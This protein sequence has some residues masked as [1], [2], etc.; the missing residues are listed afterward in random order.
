MKTAIATG[1]EPR[2][3]NVRAVVGFM[4]ILAVVIAVLIPIIWYM[5]RGLDNFFAGQDP[6][7]SPVTMERPVPLAP[8]QRSPGHD[9]LDWQDMQTMRT[10]QEAALSSTTYDPATG[11]GHISI[12]QAMDL[13]LSHNMLKTASPAAAPTPVQPQQGGP[14]NQ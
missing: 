8:L 4:V 12:D 1:Y 5:Y 10:D 3:A 9:T 6:P 7:A 11:K 2:D 14:F 13:L